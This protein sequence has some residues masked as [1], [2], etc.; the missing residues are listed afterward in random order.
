MAV[1]WMANSISLMPSLGYH[2]KDTLRS[3]SQ[4]KLAKRGI[5]THKKTVTWEDSCLMS[6]IEHTH[7]S[8]TETPY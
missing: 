5:P 1:A 3:S 8:K 6:A 4:E 2:M 7:N